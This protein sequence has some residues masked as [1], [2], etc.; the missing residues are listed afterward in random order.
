MPKRLRKQALAE[1]PKQRLIRPLPELANVFI[2]FKV[3]ARCQLLCG[4]GLKHET[5]HRDS[6]IR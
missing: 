6:Q 4:I 3:K 5:H 1:G 2:G